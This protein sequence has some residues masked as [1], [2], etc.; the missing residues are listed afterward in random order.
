MTGLL[1]SVRD[2]L[3]AQ[4]ALNS[5]ADLIDLKEPRRGALGRCDVAV[6]Q[7]VSRYVSG[8]CPVS[9]ALGELLF[10]LPS[11]R[12]DDVAGLDFAKIGLAGCQS[13][14]DWVARWATALEC[15]PSS[16]CKVAVA[17][18]DHREA[19]SPRPEEVLT[20]GVRLGCR[21]LL[22]DTCGKR[23]GSLFNYMRPAEVSS[24]LQ[25]A[26]AEQM[27]TVLGGSLSLATLETALKLQPGYVA[28]RGS[29][30]RGDR[31]GS[32]DGDLVRIW[33]DRVAGSADAGEGRHPSAAR[34]TSGVRGTLG[35]QQV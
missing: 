31:M 7:E 22:L 9:A 34:R 5:G 4:L 18:A 35:E 8:R 11:D 19:D 21:A 27:V 10:D 16:T 13:V 26:H 15:I 3:E 1:I 17:Y 2:C 20:T 29:V 6:W 32:L 33:A 14:V 28:L 30:C 12:P 24:L 23:G 25:I